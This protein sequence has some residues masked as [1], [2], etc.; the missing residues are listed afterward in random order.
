MQE[1]V[2]NLIE[3]LIIEV[4]PKVQHRPTGQ[5]ALQKGQVGWVA[6]QQPSEPLCPG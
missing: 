1:K 2:T 4:K 3:V 5:Q 6:M